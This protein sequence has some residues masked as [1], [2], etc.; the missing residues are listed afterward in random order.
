MEDKEDENIRD[1]PL[2]V[3][4]EGEQWSLRDER[5]LVWG[6]L[7]KAGIRGQVGSLGFELGLSGL[8]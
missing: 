8:G 3:L 5:E 4:D 7:G 6:G 2:G 1:D